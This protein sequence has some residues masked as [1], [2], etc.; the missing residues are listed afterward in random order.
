MLNSYMEQA[1]WAFPRLFFLSDS[2]LLGLLAWSRNPKD[3]LLYVKK[4]YPGIV[5]LKFTLPQDSSLKL[6]ATL[7]AALNGEIFD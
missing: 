5:G 7:D 4:C 2:D 6:N 3:L 1:R